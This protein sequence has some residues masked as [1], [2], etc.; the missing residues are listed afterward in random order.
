MEHHEM[1]DLVPLYALDAL[2]GSELREFEAH[3][4]TCQVCL[5]ELAIHQ[6]VAAAL[7]VDEPAPGPVWDRV[8]AAVSNPRQSPPVAEISARR[9]A[10]DRP[11]KWI[12][13]VAA[14]AALLLALLAV[15]QAVEMNR[16]TG[17]EGV[18][19]A[20]EAAAGE[21]GAIVADLESPT[22]TV[23]R[24]VLTSDGEGFLLPADLEPLSADR[25]YQLW[26]ITPGEGA[27]SAGVLGNEPGPVRFTF[28]GDVAG[29]ALTREVAGGVASTA[30]DVVGAVEL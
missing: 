23:A 28:D 8:A 30:G 9:A 27:I 16:V 14:V 25:T 22:G 10:R 13:A 1:I 2:E 17:P 20:A 18:L 19:A 3:L 15:F 6:S 4:E 5:A 11:L 29:F 24:V 7:I 26:V 21:P 12:A